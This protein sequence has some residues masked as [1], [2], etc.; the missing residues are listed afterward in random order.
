MWISKAARKVSAR[1]R[2]QYGISCLFVGASCDST[3]L[4][5]T[6]VLSLVESE[7]PLLSDL[8]DESFAT[9]SCIVTKA[10]GLL[11]VINGGENP[12]FYLIDGLARVAQTEFN[13]IMIV[14][15]ALER[16]KA[17]SKDHSTIQT[18]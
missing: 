9:L 12:R 2:A 13:T 10:P 15:L 1:P 7:Y 6:F 3:Y 8:K 18:R 16:Y 5:R 11:W 17:S 4:Q 14:T